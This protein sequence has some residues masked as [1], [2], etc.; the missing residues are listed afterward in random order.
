MYTITITITITF[1]FTFTFTSVLVCGMLIQW[2]APS[3]T[4]DDALTPFQNPLV[5]NN[6][7]RTSLHFTLTA[8]EQQETSTRDANERDKLP[9]LLLTFALFYF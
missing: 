7:H 2:V 5:Q 1:T 4:S 9:V 6:N 3:L 8:R